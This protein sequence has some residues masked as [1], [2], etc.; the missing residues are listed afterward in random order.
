RQVSGAVERSSGSPGGRRCTR[1][2]PGVAPS[3]PGGGPRLSHRSMTR[4]G[5]YMSEPDGGQNPPQDPQSQ[6]Q[7][8]QGPPPQDAQSQRPQ[9]QG[10]EGQPAPEPSA[11]QP[12]TSA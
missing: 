9:W 2:I 6:G 7:Q 3:C 5:K 11:P 4:E 12:G 8:P 10:Q 1:A